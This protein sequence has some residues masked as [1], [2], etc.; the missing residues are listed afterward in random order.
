MFYRIFL[1][2]TNTTMSDYYLDTWYVRVSSR[3]AV[4]LKTYDHREL[5]II[6][7]YSK[8]RRMLAYFSVPV[9]K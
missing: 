1:L 7:K 5:G 6:K 3:V 2:T 4:R 8:L 9:P